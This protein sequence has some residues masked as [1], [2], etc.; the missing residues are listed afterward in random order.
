MNEENVH[1]TITMYWFNKCSPDHVD[2]CLV[3]DW[4]KSMARRAERY[5]FSE[6]SFYPKP[7]FHRLWGHAAAFSKTRISPVPITERLWELLYVGH[8]IE[9][10]NWL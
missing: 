6:F 2:Y 9:Q 5:G 1:R 3:P 7:M 4:V 10:A 8:S